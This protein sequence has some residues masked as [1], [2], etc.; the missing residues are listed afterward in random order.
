MNRTMSR[1]TFLILS[2]GTAG[3]GAVLGG[4]PDASAGQAAKSHGPVTP[5]KTVARFAALK[6]NF[7]VAFAYPDA[8]SPCAVLRMSVPVAGGIGPDRS[9]V[10]FS[11]L[12]THMGCP[13]RYDPAA[14]TFKCPCHYSIFDPEKAGQMVIGQATATLPRILLQYFAGNDTIVAVGVE[15][16]IYGRQTNS[17]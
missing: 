4:L 6:P 16:L 7:P 17:L 5:S 11:T 10:A 14:K 2:G 13:L 9:V 1:R 3:A 8:A 15:G 12:C